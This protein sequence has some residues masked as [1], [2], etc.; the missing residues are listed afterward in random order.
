[1]THSSDRSSLR[2]FRSTAARA[3]R[4]RKAEAEEKKGLLYHMCTKSN[5]FSLLEQH[6][7][8]MHRLLSSW[9]FKITNITNLTEIEA[10]LFGQGVWKSS[11]FPCRC[12]LDDSGSQ[13]LD[14][15]DHLRNLLSN[16]VELENRLT[17]STYGLHGSGWLCRDC[18]HMHLLLT[19]DAVTNGPSIVPGAQCGGCLTRS[20]SDHLTL[21]GRLIS[22]F[23]ANELNPIPIRASNAGGAR[24]LT[25]GERQVLWLEAQILTQEVA[26]AEAY[27]SQEGSLTSNK[28]STEGRQGRKHR[29][30]ASMQTE[31][32][33]MV[34]VSKLL[35]EA[36]Q[37]PMTLWQGE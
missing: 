16:P 6:C 18:I 25:F 36:H 3:H 17:K 5:S 2:N 8:D 9:V 26:D 24:N 13:K 20:T 14:Q 15:H 27:R 35:L 32:E 37:N 22:L 4:S 23:L 29:D 31:Y 1:M 30:P 10:T 19:W 33:Y 34:Y 21:L 11:T 12:R 7:K 28:L